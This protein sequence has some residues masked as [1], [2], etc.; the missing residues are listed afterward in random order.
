M[1]FG[2]GCFFCDNER[3]LQKSSIP[4]AEKGNLEWYR[5]INNVELKSI[6]TDIYC[7]REITF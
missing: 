5:F 6:D 3:K 4:L 2:H 7:I 1:Q